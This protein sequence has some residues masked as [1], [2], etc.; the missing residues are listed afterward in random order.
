M[1]KINVL[2]LFPD[3]FKTPLESS[4]LGRAIKNE[5]VEVNL[6]DI[7]HFTTDK[8][9][10]TDNRPFGGGPGMVLKVEPI[11]RALK[12]LKP[13]GHVILTSAK[14]KTFTQQLAQIWSRLPEITLI[15]GHYEGV[16][17]RVAKNLID[18]E[19][20]IGD[21]VM[22]GGEP[23]SLVMIDTMARLLPKALANQAS[24]V[25]ES[26]SQPGSLGF[27]QYTRPAS[28]KGWQ[29]PDDLLSGNHSSIDKWRHHQKKPV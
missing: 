16:D 24:P 8:H 22:T 19:V 15:C 25:N 14:G 1:L 4:I 10:T 9:K 18:E 26:H 5:L 20:R 17:E 12:S 27:P 6:V 28:F 13:A 21:Y 2:T 29:V 11:Y 3:Y 7:R 23:A